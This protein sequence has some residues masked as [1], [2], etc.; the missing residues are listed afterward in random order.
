ML[1]QNLNAMNGLLNG[2]RLIVGK[3]YANSLDLEIITDANIGQRVLI[4]RID[5]S[6]SDATVPFSFKRRQFPIRLALCVTINKALG[7]T[8][9]GVEIYLPKPVFSHEQLYVAS[10][11]GKSFQNVRVGIKPKGSRTANIVWKEV[12]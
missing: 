12:L 1:L 3:M 7:Q 9:E 5:L 8:I 4:P 2:T 6:P 11:R 10:S